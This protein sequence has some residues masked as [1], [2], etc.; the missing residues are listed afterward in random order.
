LPDSRVEIVHV[1]VADLAAQANIAPNE[2][3]LAIFWSNDSPAGQVYGSADSSGRV[4]V[5]ALW[6]ALGAGGVSLPLHAM[7]SRHVRPQTATIVICTRDRPEALTRCLASLRTQTRK[8]DQ[9]VVVDNASRD[10]RT[11]RAATMAGVDYVREDRTG[12]DIAR[13]TGAVN[14]TSQIIAYTDDDVRLH[15]RWLERLV[16]A[17]DTEEVMAV[18]GLVLPAELET[19]AQLIFEQ[20][21]GF[22]RGFSRIDFDSAFFERNR[23]YGCPVWQIGAGASMAFRRRAFEEVGYFDERLD[24]GAA[25]CSGDSEYWYRLLAAG[26]TCRYEPSAVAFHFHRRDYES[27]ARQIFAYMRGHTAALLVQFE[28]H[29]HQGNLRRIFRT[30]PRWYAG[31]AIHRFWHGID[32]TNCLLSQEVRGALAGI[33]YYLRTK[34]HLPGVQL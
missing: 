13:N 18:T 23:D 25:G 31:R 16:S 22:G 21:W 2:P 34:R 26:W 6:Q 3:V 33:I 10:S 9:V 27:L 1:D 5:Q 32:D 17:F 7:V 8:P 14:A 28:R 30:L 19:R 20:Q 24:V 4:G 15:P 12:L 29:G 11:E